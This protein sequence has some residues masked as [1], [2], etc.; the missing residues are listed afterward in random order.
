[1]ELKHYLSMLWRWWWL[2]VVATLLAGGISYWTTSQMPRIYSATTTLLVGQV[3]QAGNPNPQD[4]STSQQL[5]QTYALLVRRQ[6]L[7]QA[8]V[9]TLGLDAQWQTVATRVT[10][11]TIPNTQLIQISVTGSDPT[12][13]KLIA[14]EVARQLVLQ[15]PAAVSREE[16]ERR[17]FASQ[18]AFSLQNR[19]R[20]AEEELR[21]LDERLAWE[22]S[23]RGVQDTQNQIAATQQKI[24]GWQKTYADVSNS[25]R[26]GRP[27]YLTI[28]EP[29]VASSKPVSPNVPRNVGVAAGIGL[30]LALGGV[31]VLEYL[32]DRVRTA[33]DVARTLKLPLLSTIVRSRQVQPLAEGFVDAGAGAVST[34]VAE[35]H[36]LLRANLQFAGV[37]KQGS[38]L[39]IASALPN[40]GK[41]TVAC[42][43]AV[44]MAQGGKRVVLCDADLRRPSVHEVFGTSNEMGLANLLMD[45][46]LPPEAALV[47]TSVARLKLLPSGQLEANPLDLVGSEAMARR[48]RQLRQIT[49]V[50]IFDSPP[51]LGLA[52]EATVLGT[53]CDGAILVVD[54]RRTRSDE[55]RNGKAMLDRAGINVLGVV[56][57]RVSE[58]TVRYER[59]DT[60]DSRKQWFGGWPRLTALRSEKTGKQAT[61]AA[62]PAKIGSGQPGNV[63]ASTVSEGIAPAV[64]LPLTPSAT[65][66]GD[67]VAADE[68]LTRP[69]AVG[70]AMSAPGRAQA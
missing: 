47:E 45:E 13:A 8:A 7:L 67:G 16:L 68:S 5:A 1:V 27:N 42:N 59:Y 32:D 64:V 63:A 41:T 40:E 2:V 66:S 38:A 6:P 57:N 21:R 69:S 36:R 3:L 51:M 49:D 58:R 50:V 23:A 17:E 46:R 12:T 28:V 30:L 4:F 65:G 25:F 53:L 35:A 39:L 52:A 22:T 54:A 70:V 18:Q 62:H 24:A 20:E 31:L 48:L 29:A 34:P 26:G 56:L 33:E 44:T 11:R 37:L 10:A 15:S 19:I 14:D 61:V 60:R 55:A 9:D 43:L